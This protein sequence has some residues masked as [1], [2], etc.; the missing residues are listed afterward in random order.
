MSRD[1]NQKQMQRLTLSVFLT[2]LISGCGSAPEPFDLE[3]SIRDGAN[4]SFSAYPSG[5]P[6]K[7]N[8][9]SL[10]F[11]GLCQIPESLYEV[12]ADSKLID[13]GLLLPKD[14]EGSL[15]TLGIDLS[16][17]AG[18]LRDDINEYGPIPDTTLVS[19]MESLAEEVLKSRIALLSGKSVS[20]A[21]QVQNVEALFERGK[22][23]C[24]WHEENS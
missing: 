7:I 11:I 22:K 5:P 15:K 19:D 16:A 23:V 24:E 9:Y 20:V 10:G 18:W 4:S 17:R 21:E 14:V 13:E 2:A 1:R 8:P 6:I 3:Q 12:Q